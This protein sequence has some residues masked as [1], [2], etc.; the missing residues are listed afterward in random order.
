MIEVEKKFRPTE[1]QLKCLLLDSEFIKEV[2]NHDIIYDYPDYR[3]IKESIRLRSRNGKFEL[4]ISEGEENNL[5]G[6][7]S[8]EIENEEEIKKHLKINSSLADFVRE[9]LIEAINIKTTRKKYKNDDFVID[10]DELDFG[11]NCVEIELLVNDNSKVSEAYE[12]IINLAKSY[13]FDLTDV[14]PKRKEYFRVVKP[15]VYKMLY[16]K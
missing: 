9:N 14:P 8:L 1:E 4:K 2:V 12:R 13:S 10:V 16:Q 3:W 11:Y 15:L 6:A 7:A 5:A